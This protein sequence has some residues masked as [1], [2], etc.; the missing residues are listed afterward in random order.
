M[1]ICKPYILQVSQSF[2]TASDYKFK[3]KIISSDLALLAYKVFN[4]KGTDILLALIFPNN[5]GS[6]DLAQ[7]LIE[8]VLDYI[9]YALVMQ[10]FLLLLE[11]S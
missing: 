4:Y 10:C 11:D 7:F 5:F 8:R 6:E 3:L 1:V 9:Y 2:K